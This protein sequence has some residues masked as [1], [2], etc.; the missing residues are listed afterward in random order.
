MQARLHPGVGLPE[1]AD[2]AQDVADTV[3]VPEFR[4]GKALR[5]GAVLLDPRDGGRRIIIESY[6]SDLNKAQISSYP[7]RK[8]YRQL[9]VSNLYRSRM[10]GAG[11]PRRSGYFFV[12]RDEDS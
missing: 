6:Q 5:E 9:V 11:E 10:T 2:A 8:R 1:D 7:S 3:G 12:G 4:I